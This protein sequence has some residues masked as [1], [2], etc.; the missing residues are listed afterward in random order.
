MP[1]PAAPSVFDTSDRLVCGQCGPANCNSFTAAR[2]LGLSQ[3]LETSG[4]K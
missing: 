2:T 1:D 4:G 3:F